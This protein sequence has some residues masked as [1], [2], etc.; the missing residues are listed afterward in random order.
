M[1][2]ERLG[3]WMEPQSGSVRPSKLW[4]RPF[5]FAHRGIWTRRSRRPLASSSSWF[6]IARVSMY[7][8]H[9]VLADPTYGLRWFP[10]IFLLPYN[11]VWILGPQIFSTGYTWLS[12]AGASELPHSAS[13][14]SPLVNFTLPQL[15]HTH[16]VQPSEK[17]SFVCNLRVGSLDQHLHRRFTFSVESNVGFS[18]SVISSASSSSSSSWLTSYYTS[19]TSSYDVE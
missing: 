5:L 18:F 12:R 11:I 9:A 16:L 19:S 7:L 1:A 2:C 13:A 17:T 3:R 6:A 14:S 4:R 8:F 15:E 10:S